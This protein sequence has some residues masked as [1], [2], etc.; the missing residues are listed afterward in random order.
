MLEG[1]WLFFGKAPQ[2]LRAVIPSGL[3]D[4]DFIDQMDI[5]SGVL[6][7]M[8]DKLRFLWYLPHSPIMQHFQLRASNGATVPW[9]PNSAST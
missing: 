2:G 1:K 9:R 4:Q 5:V 3:D 8:E 7:T 6:V